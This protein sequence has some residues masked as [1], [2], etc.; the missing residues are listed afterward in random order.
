MMT[1]REALDLVPD[2]RSSQGRRH[3]LGA[4]LALA[5]CAMLCGARSLYA[6]AQWGRD[7]GGATAQLLGFS[8]E[9]T[10]CV[11]TLHRVFKDLDV[12]AFEAEVGNWL[13]NSG[14]EADD[15]LSLDGKT[16]RGVH[17]QEIPGVHL[18]SAYA[19]R[20]GAVLAQVAAPGKGEELVAVKEVLGQVPLKGRVVV[21]DALLTQRKV[22]EQIVAGGGEY[23][24]PV[25]EN[26]PTLRRDLEVAF[27]LL[28]TERAGG[29]TVPPWLAA[30]W[31]AR[32]AKLTVWADAPVKRRHGRLE[33][34]E[35][36][37][38]ADPELNGYVGSAGTVGEA[39][40]HLQQVCRLERQRVVK[41]KKQV[42]VSYAISSLPATDADAR[43]LLSLSRGHWGIEN[44]LHWVRDV[45]FDEDRSQVRTGAAPQV[46][47]GLRNLVISLVRRAGHSNVAAALRRHNAHLS[48]AFDMMGFF[49][50]RQENEKALVNQFRNH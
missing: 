6:I 2:F 17:G 24:L 10:P 41:G 46:L 14:V 8:Q 1:L 4:I 48:E 13:A 26:Q 29:P 42:A 34:R 19:S 38:L 31:R 20:A 40:P 36:W 28:G 37:A 27:P 23:L 22:C 9:K 25:K 18:V 32:G 30:E 50:T 43:R 45:T 44:R 12:A 16:L 3:S 33:R 11:A 15:P 7:Q 21:A 49:P 47:A 39:W 35:L 5:T